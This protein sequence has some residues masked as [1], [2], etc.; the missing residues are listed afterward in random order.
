[1]AERNQ[2]GAD[3]RRHTIRRLVVGRSRKP[4]VSSH[5]TARGFQRRREPHRKWN[6]QTIVDNHFRGGPRARRRLRRREVEWH[7]LWRPVCANELERILI[8]VHGVRGSFVRLELQAVANECA[9][10]IT[11]EWMIRIRRR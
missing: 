4:A 7:R 6:A 11:S 1:A 9:A 2:A 5:A 3:R 10:W 8:N